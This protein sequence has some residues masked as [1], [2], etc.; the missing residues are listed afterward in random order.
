M[1]E[2]ISIHIG[3]A[4]IQVGNSCWELY[5]LEHGI[6]P[7]GMMPR[8]ALYIL[9]SLH[10]A[11]GAWIVVLWWYACVFS[12]LCAVMILS[13]R[14][15][16]K[17]WSGAHLDLPVNVNT[18]L[19]RK[20]MHSNV[21]GL[22]FFQ[23]FFAWMTLRWQESTFFELHFSHFLLRTAFASLDLQDPHDPRL[24]DLI[25]LI[26]CLHH[27]YTNITFYSTMVSTLRHGAIS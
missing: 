17:A 26:L 27:S 9:I 4:G 19:S 13:Y 6:Q 1:R 7:D 22:W 20:I 25:V 10:L 2:I 5:C 14:I 23:R 12:D 11:F 21:V 3:Q 8:Y 24:P 18:F 16:W 15:C